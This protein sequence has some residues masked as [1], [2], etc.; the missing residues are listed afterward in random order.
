[1]ALAAVLVS[2]CAT[3]PRQH[4][5]SP[6][7]PERNPLL[8]STLWWQLSSEALAASTQ[9]YASARHALDRALIENPK[10]SAALEQE[11]GFD[12][13]PPAI[14]M[15]LDETVLDNGSY[16]GELIRLGKIEYSPP[17]WDAWLHRR[18]AAAVPGAIEFIRYAQRHGVRVFFVTNRE[19]QVREAASDPCPQQEDTAV[20]LRRLGVESTTLA[21]DL[22][23]KNE[24]PDWTSEKKSR[25]ESIARDYRI[26]L[27][28]GDD[29]GDF[30]AGVKSKGI[31]V[32]QRRELTMS[33][34]SYW[35]DRWFMLANPMYG[36]WEQT[37]AKPASGR[38]RNFGE[39]ENALPKGCEE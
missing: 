23:L 4:A 32:E 5:D 12:N 7:P 14:V 16:Q 8:L 31:T 1:M 30:M 18:Q 25:R 9:T 15:D 11:T 3:Q 21:D 2:G 10:R 28:F 27:L 26:V 13:K 37:L 6:V 38:L 24:R 33:H 35:G 39:G 29:L 20:N 36:S 17:M 22:L 19:C 34:C